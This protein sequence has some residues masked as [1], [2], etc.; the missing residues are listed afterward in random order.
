MSINITPLADRVVVEAAAA[1]ETSTGGIILPDTAQEKPQQG[2][3]VAVGPG[4]VS[5]AGTLIEMTVKKGD[6]VLYGKYSGSDVTFDGN[7]YMIMRESDI[8]AIL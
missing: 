4:K 2:K 6:K 1:E 3:V 7:E 5:D 8:L